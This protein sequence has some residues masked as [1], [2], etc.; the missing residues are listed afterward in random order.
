M[1]PSERT[2]NV[3]DLISS[4]IRLHW[5]GSPSHSLTVLRV[6]LAA[7]VAITTAHILIAQPD[8]TFYVGENGLTVDFFAA[9]NSPGLTYSWDF[10]DGNSGS[11]RQT[12][13]TYASPGRYTVTLTVTDSLNVS[14]SASGSVTASEGGD[15][16]EEE[17][18][19][20]SGSGGSSGQPG[21]RIRRRPTPQTCQ[22]E[23]GGAVKVS[24]GAPGIQCRLIDN[25]AGIGNQEI[26]AAGYL[27]AVDVWSNV[28]G[29]A[30][31][32]FR[33]IGEIVLLDAATSPRRLIRL[34]A[35]AA[36]GWTCA[37][38]DR[39]GTVVLLPGE[40]SIGQEQPPT[41]R[42]RIGLPSEIWS[43]DS[44]IVPLDGCQVTTRFNLNFRASPG[45]A[46]IGRTIVGA[47][48]SLDANRRTE[49]WF[50][51][52]YNAVAGWITAHFVRTAGACDLPDTDEPDENESVHSVEQDTDARESETDKSV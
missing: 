42:T 9:D 23:L 50:A 38:I 13:H 47:G 29:G 45:G 48:K 46:R 14:S 7:V 43:D 15:P 6:I 5:I 26:V 39:A 1:I 24:A 19:G 44:A 41:A 20:S 28:Q 17:E 30:Q 31:V 3:R 11:G 2:K 18:G 51:V 21:F 33:Q 52:E 36:D 8:A 35:Y 49:H 27:A 4:V 16:D 25:P 12:S 10:G 32:C 22:T 40:P 34:S 37:Q